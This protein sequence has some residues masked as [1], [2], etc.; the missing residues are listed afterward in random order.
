MPFHS[1]DEFVVKG[2]ALKKMKIDFA[3]W[4]AEL[5]EG[6]RTLFEIANRLIERCHSAGIAALR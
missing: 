5:Q 3:L 2:V 6:V 1:F 4:S